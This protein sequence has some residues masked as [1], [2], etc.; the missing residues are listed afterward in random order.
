MNVEKARFNMVEQQIRP[1]ELVDADVQELLYAVKREEFVPSA[2]FALAFADTEIPL[3][4]G[5]TLPLPGLAARALQVLKVRKSDRVLEIGSGSGYMAALLAAHGERVWTV[6]IVPE[7]VQLARDNLARQHITNVTVELGN[8]ANG[9]PAH[10]PYNVIMVSGALPHLPKELLAQLK[11]GGR[12]F[13]VVGE[14]PAM[15]AQLVTRSGEEGFETDSLFETQLAPLV[16]GPRS[17]RFV[18]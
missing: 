9:W 11:P 6:E 1:W 3:G 5:A 10:A 7:L 16:D 13:A 4:H 14:G 18:F 8:G 2:Y 12:L 17:E 15:T